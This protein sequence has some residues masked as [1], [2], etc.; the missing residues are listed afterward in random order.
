VLDELT[1]GTELELTTPFLVTLGSAP[2]G[3]VESMIE[4]QA[5]APSFVLPPK[6]PQSMATEIRY[7]GLAVVGG[8]LHRVLIVD[9]RGRS[10]VAIVHRDQMERS[11]VRKE[12]AS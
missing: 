7:I 5:Q 11:L 1:P 2:E 10:H 12:E 8:E 6:L 4:G 9:H 3:F